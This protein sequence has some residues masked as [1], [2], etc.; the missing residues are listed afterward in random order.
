M[1]I[2]FL[3]GILIGIAVAAPI[4]P[5]GLLCV[6]K[7]LEFGF[8]GTVAVGLGT[9]M[10]D[11]LYAGIVAFGLAAFSGF[12]LGQVVY[13]KIFGG[14]LLF[15]LAAKEYCSKSPVVESV[16]ITKK[17][18]L[19]VV[20]STFLLTLCNPI[21]IVSFVGIF[22]LLGDNLLSMDDAALMVL[23]VFTGS[24]VW[25]L[26]LGRIIHHTKHLLPEKFI[27]SIRKIS[28]LILAGFGTWAF[29]SV[30]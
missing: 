29:L 23:G 11:A 15:A 12:L 18:W 25:F 22:A 19:A 3:T 5:I 21:G 20:A 26:T 30:V 14:I 24:M 13:F 17:S 10:A 27:A 9:A 2:T 1:I 6:R 7:T 8:V 28:A 16:Q 4:G